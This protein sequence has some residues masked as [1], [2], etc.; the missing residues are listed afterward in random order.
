VD[1][2]RGLNTRLAKCFEE[3]SRVLARHTNVL[4]ATFDVT[5]TSNQIFAEQKVHPSAW[6]KHAHI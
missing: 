3:T 5:A 6:S 4:E 2:I 1:E